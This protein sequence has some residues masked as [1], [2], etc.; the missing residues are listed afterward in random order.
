[1]GF[2][3]PALIQLRVLGGLPEALQGPHPFRVGVQ[4]ENSRPGS[5]TSPEGRPSPGHSSSAFWDPPWDRGKQSLGYKRGNQGRRA[6]EL[7]HVTCHVCSPEMDS[8][9]VSPRIYLL[10]PEPPAPRNVTVFGEKAF[11]ELMKV[12]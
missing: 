9:A 5:L 11:T 6:R 4:T 2:P 3:G 12:K 10:K 8:G 7:A 1:M